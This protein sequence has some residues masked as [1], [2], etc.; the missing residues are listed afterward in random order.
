MVFLCHSSALTPAAMK[1]DV[2]E[3]CVSKQPAEVDK[4]EAK[5]KEIDEKPMGRSGQRKCCCA[6]SGDGVVWSMRKEKKRRKGRVLGWVTLD[7]PC[8]KKGVV[9]MH[10]IPICECKAG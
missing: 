9:F 7:P 2:E 6:S 3:E 1:R 5:T 4:L 8:P 10:D